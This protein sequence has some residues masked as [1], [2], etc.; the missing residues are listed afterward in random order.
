AIRAADPARCGATLASAHALVPRYALLAVALPDGTLACSSPPAGGTVSVAARSYFVDAVRTRRFAVGEYQV[1]WVSGETTLNVA[2]PVVGESGDVSAVVVAAVRVAALGESLDAIELPPGGALLAV[3]RRGVVLARRPDPQ[4]WVGGEFAGADVVRRMRERGS[5]VERV[6]GVDGVAREYAFRPLESLPEGTAWLAVGMPTDSIEGSAL[7]E[8]A[9]QLALLVAVAAAAAGVALWG[10]HVFLVRP[11]DAIIGAARQIQS[12]DLGARVATIRPA[13][14]ADRSEIGRLA[15]AFDG[16][17]ATVARRERDILEINQKLRRALEDLAAAQSK[18]LEQERLRALGEMASGIAHDFN[19]ALSPVVGFSELLLE[20]PANLKDPELARRYLGLIRTGAEDAMAV[21]ARLR[22][23]YRPR[24]EGQTFGAVDL[25]A[26]VRQ[27]VQ[28][29]EPRWRSQAQSGGATI[30]VETDLDD[31][32]PVA[33]D[34]RELREALTNLIFNA[35]DAMPNGG[36]L[37]LRTRGEEGE[38]VLEVGDT[39]VGM[40]EEVRRRCLEPFF[41][42]KGARGTGLGLSMV[43]GTVRRHGGEVEIESAVGKG[44]TF[45]LRL[46]LSSARTTTDTPDAA[47]DSAGRR[48]RVLLV[49]DEEPVR[50][51]T[52]AYLLAEGHAVEEAETGRGALERFRA[53]RF[54]VVIT[55]RAMPDMSGDQVAAAVKAASPATPVIMLTGF[56][57][58]MLA[59]DERPEE[60]DVVVGKPLTRRALRDAL[61][62]V[63]RPTE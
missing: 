50:A 8:L 10:G 48:L 55:D 22:E 39:G 57:G 32:P 16:M 54:D 19:N 40:T 14:A 59:A 61:G 13:V 31:V 21:V 23:F 43:Y 15:R 49:D 38:A 5:G 58:L 1:G 17:A 18:L 27:A 44:T 33:G 11:V 36:T 12:G 37:T 2:E 51:A 28:L 30:R 46:P 26:M 56:G 62:V 53:A 4:R 6:R 29:T 7:R 52:R 25:P 9:G 45:R 35:V 20:V 34:E 3:D 60:V 47:P 63:A 42:T 24:D 41:S